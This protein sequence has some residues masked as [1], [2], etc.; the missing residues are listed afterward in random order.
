MEA[1]EG[2]AG[3]GP[4][5][6]VQEVRGSNFCWGYQKVLLLVQQTKGVTTK[7]KISGTQQ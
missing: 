4:G 3:R 5:R 7:V 1:H 6:E 2:R